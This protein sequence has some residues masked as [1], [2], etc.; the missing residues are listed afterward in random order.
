MDS[1]NPTSDGYNIYT[2]NQCKYQANNRNRIKSTCLDIICTLIYI[3]VV[4][5]SLTYRSINLYFWPKN[6]IKKGFK[7]KGLNISEVVHL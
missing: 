4:N 2:T 3:H 1:D 5:N 7:F 6:Y